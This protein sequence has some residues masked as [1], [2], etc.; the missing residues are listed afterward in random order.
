MGASVTSRL[1]RGRKC[2]PESYIAYHAEGLGHGRGVLRR[3]VV[4]DGRVLSSERVG[5]PGPLAAVRQHE[6]RVK[7]P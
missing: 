5:S 1:R 2:R 3:D 7:L 6:R 4:L